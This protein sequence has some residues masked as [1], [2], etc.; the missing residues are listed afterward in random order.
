MSL[1][2]KILEYDFFLSCRLATLNYGTLIKN[3]LLFVLLLQVQ[4]LLILRKIMSS[5]FVADLTLPNTKISFEYKK[6]DDADL[7]GFELEPT[8]FLFF[9]LKK[10]CII[11]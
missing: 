10:I 2:P 4:N 5:I 6:V 8:I 11:F 7:S 9:R 1:R 3:W